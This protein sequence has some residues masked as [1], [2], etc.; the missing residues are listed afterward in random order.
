[1]RSSAGERERTDLYSRLPK[2]IQREEVSGRRGAGQC[3]W[4]VRGAWP[5]TKTCGT[6]R[7]VWGSETW[8]YIAVRDPLYARDRR[9]S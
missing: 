2:R 6:Q 3:R 8:E 4:R 1:M 9:R 7:A 5:W